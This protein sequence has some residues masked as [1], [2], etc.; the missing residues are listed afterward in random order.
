MV[1]R[2]E[3][4]ICG[5]QNKRHQVHLKLEHLHFKVTIF[6]GKV[7][8]SALTAQILLHSLTPLLINCQFRFG[9]DQ[10]T[11]NHQSMSTL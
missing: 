7:I 3:F 11:T 1:L 10:C 8:P 6:K 2:L 4:R 9:E 5:N